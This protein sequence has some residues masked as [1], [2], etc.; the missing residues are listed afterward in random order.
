LEKA[1]LALDNSAS[2]AKANF[3]PVLITISFPLLLSG[4]RASSLCPFKIRAS[5]NCDII[6]Y[7]RS[8][9][10]AIAMHREVCGSERKSLDTKLSNYFIASAWGTAEFAGRS[11]HC[12]AEG[13][14]E[15]R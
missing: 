7:S 8:G 15:A 14:K 6:H 9:D 5:H 11:R 10:I 2:A 1:R 4:L 12:H 13:Q 3:N